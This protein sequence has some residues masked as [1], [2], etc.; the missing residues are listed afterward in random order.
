MF[1]TCDSVADLKSVRKQCGNRFYGGAM[2]RLFSIRRELKSSPSRDNHFVC[3]PFLFAGFAPAA[4]ERSD[5]SL[6]VS[7]FIGL[8]RCC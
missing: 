5:G 6:G 7:D 8:P 3:F 1:T 2:T 4:A